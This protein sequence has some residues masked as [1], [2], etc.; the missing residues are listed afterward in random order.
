M[1]HFERRSG[2]EDFQTRESRLRRIVDRIN[3]QVRAESSVRFFRQ[4]TTSL[5]VR[6]CLKIWMESTGPVEFVLN[7][8]EHYSQWITN[9]GV[10]WSAEKKRKI[11]ENL[12]VFML[13]W[14]QEELPG[15]EVLGIR[16]QTGL[17]INCGTVENLISGAFGNE[18]E[19]EEILVLEVEEE[20]EGEE[21]ECGWNCDL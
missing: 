9:K 5:V 7:T 15:R 8:A 18:D 10:Q 20:E 17:N 2:F 16:Q 6:M 12:S 19:E 14:F 3:E 13:T 11:V 21:E 1:Y 4:L